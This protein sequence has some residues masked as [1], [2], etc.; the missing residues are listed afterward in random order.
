MKSESFVKLYRELLESASW[1]QLS[2]NARRLLDFLMIEHMRHGGKQNGFLQ[3]PR[4]QLWDFGI[5]AHFISDAIAEVERAGLVDCKRGIGRRPST[6]SLTWLPL[7]DGAEPSYRWRV[8]SAKQHSKEM[9]AV[10]TQNECQ[11]ALTKRVAS[12]KQH[13]QSPNSSSAKQHSPS[14]SSYQGGAVGSVLEGSAGEQQGAA[15][16][17]YVT[18][19]TGHRHCGK[20]TDPGREY[21]SEH[22]AGA[23]ER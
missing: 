3:A 21:C 7:H 6:Y 4:R 10:S 22:D 19:G 12:A 1:R 13:S 16:R 18:N 15:C 17:W 23:G 11:T 9:S 8:A 2:I 5:S 20:P 14:R